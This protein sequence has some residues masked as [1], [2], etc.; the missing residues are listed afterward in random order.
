MIVLE[1]AD[2]D[3]ATTIAVE[4]Y[5]NAGQVCLSGTRL[6]VHKNIADKFAEMFVDKAKQI[7]QGDPRLEE[8]QIVPQIHGD[9]FARIS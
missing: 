6:L 5:D 8:T 4:Q 9:H 7:K 3:L 1:D 2:L